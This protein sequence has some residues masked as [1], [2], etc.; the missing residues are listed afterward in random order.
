LEVL[1]SSLPIAEGKTGQGAIEVKLEVGG[2]QSEGLGVILEGRCKISLLGMGPAAVV[3][4][5]EALLGL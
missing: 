5:Q 4:G 3:Q 2:I 1:A